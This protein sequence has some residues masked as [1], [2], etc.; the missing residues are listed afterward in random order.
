[1]PIPIRESRASLAS[2]LARAGEAK[3]SRSL[4]CACVLVY[5]YVH[6]FAYNVLSKGPLVT[7]VTY[8]TAG[9]RGYFRAAREPAFSRLTPSRVNSINRPSICIYRM[10]ICTR[11]V[12]G[13][14]GIALDSGVRPREFF[15]T[16]SEGCVCV[17]V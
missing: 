17:V 13:C 16:F 10:R 11:G 1:M 8:A 14:G 6:V 12:T 7:N 5:I 4:A 9:E 2:I 3:L 15:M